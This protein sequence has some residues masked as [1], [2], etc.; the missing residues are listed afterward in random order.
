MGRSRELA[1]LGAAYD[2]GSLSFRNR[3]INGDMRIDQ[4]NAGAS[5]SLSTAFVYTV[6]RFC[7]VRGASSTATGQRSTTAPAG[8]INSL[9]YTVGTGASPASADFSSI[10]Q[11]VEG[12]NIADLGWGSANAQPVTLSFWA[13]S[14]V[15][16][17]FGVVLT[18]SGQTHAYATTFTISSANTFEYKTITVP[19][20]AVGTWLTDNG[21]GI[22]LSFDMGVGS[23]QS[24][25]ASTSWQSGNYL[26]V[27]STTKLCATSGATFYITGVQLE[28]GTVATPFERRPYGTELALCQR[29]CYVL[30]SSQAYYRFPPGYNNNTTTGNFPVQMP[31]PMRSIPSLTYSGATFQEIAGTGGTTQGSSF[32]IPTDG[33]STETVILFA[34]FSSGTVTAGA[35]S[36]VRIVNTTSWSAQFSSEL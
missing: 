3:I 2:G 18:N 25:A 17:T 36:A 10:R 1:E 23:T 29:Y 8:F 5:V 20:P 28:A 21:S 13:R 34:T 26:G 22:V 9:L 7:A 31:V 33:N 24:V 6:D 15:T 11:V 12:L 19:G 16:G 32:S 35:A 27:S 4:R 30:R 14:S